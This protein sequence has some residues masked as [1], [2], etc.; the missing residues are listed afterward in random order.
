MLWEKGIKK[1]S[2]RKSYNWED[3]ILNIHLLLNSVLKMVIK[4][5]PYKKY[6]E[7]VIE[8]TVQKSAKKFSVIEEQ[9]LQM[10]AWQHLGTSVKAERIVRNQQEEC[11][12][13]YISKD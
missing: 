2:V 11:S 5:E 1:N 4:K 9:P 12:K 10:N 7:N 6:T 8:S 13:T 3:H